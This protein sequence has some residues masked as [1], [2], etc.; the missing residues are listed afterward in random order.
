MRA[1]IDACT[2]VGMVFVHRIACSFPPRAHLATALL[3][4]LQQGAIMS[5]GDLMFTTLSRA[6]TAREAIQVMDYLC[7]KVCVCEVHGVR[8][9]GC[10]VCAW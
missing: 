6:K 5:Y 10:S 3:L 4:S 9:Q 1:D 2:R 8:Q 7:Q